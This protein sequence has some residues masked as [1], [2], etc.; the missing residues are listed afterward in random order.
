MAAES[1][2]PSGRSNLPDAAAHTH[3]PID[4]I[5]FLFI[6]RNV[7]VGADT[8]NKIEFFALLPNK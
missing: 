6:L 8:N 4:L 7:F 5:I 1:N 2:T 3:R